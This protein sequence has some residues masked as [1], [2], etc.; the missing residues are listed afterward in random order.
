MGD[1]SM[2]RMKNDIRM[3]AYPWN[4]QFF[5]GYPE[6]IVFRWRQEPQKGTDLMVYIGGNDYV[7]FGL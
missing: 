3:K 5:R 7:Y 2:L 1:A 6:E 4:K